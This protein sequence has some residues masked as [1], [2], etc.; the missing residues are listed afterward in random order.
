MTTFQI[1]HYGDT[2]RSSPRYETEELKTI[3]LLAIHR[4]YSMDHS[5]IRRGVHEMTLTFRLGFYLQE[6]FPEHDVDC[7][8][9]R[10]GN[11]PKS[12][13]ETARGH[14]TRPDILVHRRGE[15][16]PHN[17][18]LIEAKRTG[19]QISERDRRKVRYFVH[20]D[21]DSHPYRYQLGVVLLFREHQFEIEFIER[22]TSSS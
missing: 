14:S 20:G 5:I 15:N 6:Y 17:L 12:T 7:E 18:V 13:P 9:N 11:D 2:L 19:A 21:Q 16:F 3:V 4:L 1:E 10:N 8:Y 22:M